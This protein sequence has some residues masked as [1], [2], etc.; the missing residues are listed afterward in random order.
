MPTDCWRNCFLQAAAISDQ[1]AYFKVDAEA[2]GPPTR[3]AA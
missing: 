3:M 1:V 2:A